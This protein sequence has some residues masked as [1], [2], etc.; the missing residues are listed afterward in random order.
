[1]ND[2]EAPAEP[3][4]E[5]T[6]GAAAS[7]GACS[8]AAARVARAI[9][10]RC[11][12][13]VAHGALNRESQGVHAQQAGGLGQLSRAGPAQN[14]PG[15]CLDDGCS[16]CRG[17]CVVVLAHIGTQYYFLLHQLHLEFPFQL[18]LNSFL[19]FLILFMFL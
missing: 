12:A 3:T 19:H 4:T 2:V 17:T 11:W 5:T 10:R 8:G 16:Y 6:G 7:P 13:R 1:M 15:A 18:F 14:R 9:G